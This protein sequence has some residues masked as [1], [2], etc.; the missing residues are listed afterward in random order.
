LDLRQL[1]RFV[2]VAEARS[3]NKAAEILAVSQPSLTRSIQL[4]E[5]SL[6]SK[7]LE[8]GPRGIYLT[9]MGEELLPYAKIILNER[10]R[11]IASLNS[12]RS[13]KGETISIGADDAF[14]ARRLPLALS[15]IFVTHPNI[16]IRV[17]QGDFREM[18]DAAREGKIDMVLGS[19]APY[20]DLG[21]LAFEPL[22]EE[23][24]SV[25]MRKDHP[26]LQ[27]GE[28]RREDL[29]GARWIVADQPAIIEGWSD[30]FTRWG[31]TAPPVGLYTS[32]PQ[33]IKQC[34][35]NSDFVSIGNYTTYAEEIESGRLV[36]L[37]FGEP[38]YHRPAGLFR[39]GETKLSRSARAFIDLLREVCED[40]APATV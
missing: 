36:P 7:L 14:S 37:N 29:V 34:L 10:D 12:L 24:A 39:R 1:K 2:A 25:L 30:V 35:L 11:A 6:D 33:L 28:P 23:G 40:E 9:A 22:A 15:R 13:Q 20:L 18:L 4:L 31:L 38:M 32:S 19:R 3:F 21:G 8:R 17:M 5:E 16:K 27:A 26:L